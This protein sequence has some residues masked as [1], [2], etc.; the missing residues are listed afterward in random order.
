MLFRSR[1]CFHI[2][3][4]P[5]QHP[6]YP[7]HPPQGIG[8]GVGPLG[9][10]AGVIGVLEWILG[11]MNTCP[12]GRRPIGQDNSLNCWTINI[13]MVS[14]IVY[15]SATVKHI[16]SIDAA[17]TYSQHPA[18]RHPHVLSITDNFTLEPVAMPS[19][20]HIESC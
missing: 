9:W 13:D 12:F 17:E 4:Y 10:G 19:N 11:Y 15:V 14:T 1:T 8:G 20:R 16:F 18:L 5:F 3:Q 7:T 6:N 2:S